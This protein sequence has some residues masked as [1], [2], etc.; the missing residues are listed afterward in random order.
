[1]LEKLNKSNVTKNKRTLGSQEIMSACM[2]LLE[3][4]LETRN[5]VSDLNK[6]NIKINPKNRC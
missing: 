6:K 4:T 5:T 2:G 3:I 1:M